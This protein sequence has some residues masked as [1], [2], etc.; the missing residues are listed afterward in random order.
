MFVA[1]HRS[2]GTN[3]GGAN[4]QQSSKSSAPRRV[5]SV[6]D[7]VRKNTE[8][9]LFY[10]IECYD[11]GMRVGNFNQFVLFWALSTDAA[12]F[13]ISKYAK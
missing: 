11:P 8:S 9:R 6:P 4:Y 5:N 12:M 10:V 13:F 3:N 1:G 2:N 7:F